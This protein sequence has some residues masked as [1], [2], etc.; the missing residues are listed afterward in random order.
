VHDIEKEARQFAGGTSGVGT[1][2]MTSKVQ[3]AQV[4]GKFGVIT[5]VA[6]G[7]RARPVV[8]LLD[9][10]NAGTVFWP[11]VSRLASRKHWIAYALKPSGTL[12]VDA[13]ARRA[14]VEGKKSLLPSGVRGVRGRF[15][16]GEAVS[17]VDDNGSEFARGLI[18]FDSDEVEKIACKKSSEL[19]ALLGYRP[20]DEV[21]HRDDLVVL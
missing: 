18:G 1:G 4:A 19:E 20:A 5:V 2:G 14:M 7:R 11:S 17:V 16:A 3:A 21:I 8:S 12:V 13:G 9:G 15:G 6:S 10:E